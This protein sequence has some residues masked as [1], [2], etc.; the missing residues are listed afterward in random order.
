MS[1]KEILREVLTTQSM[2]AG[3]NAMLISLIEVMH[4]KG[5]LID[6]EK[7]M[8]KFIKNVEISKEQ[9]AKMNDEIDEVLKD[10]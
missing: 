1:N 3:I 7:V 8:E 4:E 10:I 2:V 9:I 6:A 5:G